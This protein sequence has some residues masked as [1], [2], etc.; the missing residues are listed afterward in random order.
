[1][2]IILLLLGNGCV[3]Q[4]YCGNCDTI[5]SGFFDEF[6]VY[7]NSIYLK[8]FFCNNAEVLKNFQG[9][10]SLLNESINFLLILLNPN[11]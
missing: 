1:M 11:F 2:N 9:L 4:Y 7:M 10:V 6:N 3:T 8:Y 5:F